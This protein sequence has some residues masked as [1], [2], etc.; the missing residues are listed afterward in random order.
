[1]TKFYVSFGGS[2]WRLCE[3]SVTGRVEGTYDRES[4]A[5]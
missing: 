4:Y 3:V 2:F 1:M 5:R